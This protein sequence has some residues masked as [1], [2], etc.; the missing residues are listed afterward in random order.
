[1]D[2]NMPTTLTSERG[3]R[4]G[5][6][7]SNTMNL[8]TTSLQTLIKYS[9]DSKTTF[10]PLRTNPA[11]ILRLV[12]TWL[13]FRGSCRLSPICQAKNRRKVKVSALTEFHCVVQGGLKSWPFLLASVS[14]VSRMTGGH[15][16]ASL[17][18][19]DYE[20]GQV[21]WLKFPFLLE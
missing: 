5:R 1:M 20:P 15:H 13:P 17:P 21:I 19:T 7:D 8:F 2:I 11:K 18:V 6:R 14:Q 12:R 16:H 4:K 3:Q 10:P 9:V